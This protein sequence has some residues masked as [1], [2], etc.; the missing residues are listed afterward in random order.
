M[1]PA[2]S[3]RR[4]KF[5]NAVFKC[6]EKHGDRLKQKKCSFLLPKVEYLGHQITEE[7]ILPLATKISA[8]L[9]APTPTNFQQLRLFLCLVNYYGKFVLNLAT[10]LQ[11]LKLLLQADTKWVWSQN[12]AKAFQEAKEKIIPAQVLTHYDPARP[13]KLAVDAS[14]YGVGVVISHSMPNG[15]ERPIA[16]ASCTLH[17][18]EK[19]TTKMKKRRWQLSMESR[20]SINTGAEGNVCC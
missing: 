15:D 6:L 7:G 18:V 2:I 3:N 19:T 12:F 4:R 1:K 9:K 8:I 16:F 5:S 14:T 13:I 17:K 10:L 11:P 20:N